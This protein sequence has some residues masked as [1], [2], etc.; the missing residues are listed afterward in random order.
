MGGP[1]KTD[2]TLLEFLWSRDMIKMRYVFN[3]Q[4][5]TVHCTYNP[6]SNASQ[7]CLNDADYLRK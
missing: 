6:V 3:A 4:P 2:P 5:F 1:K 7:Y